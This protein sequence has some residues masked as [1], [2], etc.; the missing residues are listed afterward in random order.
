MKWME[1]LRTIINTYAIMLKKIH[2][3]F[4]LQLVFS[5]FV[6]SEVALDSS[7]APVVEET[8]LELT[9][10]LFVN[11]TAKPGEENA[12]VMWS[13]DHDSYAQLKEQNAKLVITYNTK[14]GKKRNKKGIEGG[15]WMYTD[16]I[17]LSETPSELKTQI[18]N[19]YN[20]QDPGPKTSKVLNYLVAKRCNNLIESAQEFI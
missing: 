16:L 10:D 14:I 13:L 11:V 5:P 4:I 20:E 17:D 12:K 19:T 15:E 9:S 8:K 3:L 1:Y 7:N 18:I 2:L 6:F